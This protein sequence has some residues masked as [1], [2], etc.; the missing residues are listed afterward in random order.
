MNIAL[1]ETHKTDM[2]HE[3]RYM[4]RIDFITLY[5]MQKYYS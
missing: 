5:D 2:E 1:Y 4:K 3:M